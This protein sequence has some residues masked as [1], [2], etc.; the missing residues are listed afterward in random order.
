M[1]VAVAPSGTAHGFVGVVPLLRFA[2]RQDR[3]RLAV[4][5]T[6]VTVMW[7][8]ASIALQAL[9]PTAADRQVRAALMASPAAVVLT[10]P[11]Y[12]TQSYTHGAMVAGEMGLMVFVAL[13]IMSAQ[14]V[15]RHTRAEEES[16][17]AELLRAGVAGRRAPFASAV[18]LVLL[19]NLVI[20]VLTGVVLTLTG[21]HAPDAFALGLAG[22]ATGVTCGAIA[23]VAAQVTDHA[24]TAS[25][26]ALAVLG[27]AFVL[28]AAGD[29]QKQ[30]GSALSWLSPLGWAQQIRAFVDL[31]LWPLALSLVLTCALLAAAWLLAAARDLGA[32]VL[33]ARP[34]RARA[35]PSLRGP[36]TL[37]WRL[38]RGSAAAWAVGV[39]A[40]ALASGTF[41]DAVVQMAQEM[42]QLDALLGGAAGAAEAFVALMAKFF[43][44]V[45]TG[46]CLAAA[47]GARHEESAGQLETILGS[48]VSRQRWLLSR[49]AVVVLMGAG[50]LVLA[51]VGL[52]AGAASVEGPTPRLGDLLVAVGAHLPALL[53][54]VGL[55]TLLTG[56]APRRVQLV[57]GWYAFTFVAS[58]YGGLLGL[59]RWAVDLSPFEHVPALAVGRA[60]WGGAG[61]LAAGSALLVGAGVAALRR[62]DI[63]GM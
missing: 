6:S 19:L 36:F 62:R 14:T 24:R 37:A 48:A 7:A 9:Y 49:W 39:A 47:A 1:T 18:V 55:A 54:F 52:W 12:G 20:A 21:L 25:G 15:V 13:A 51:G 44:I 57:W 4:W 29:V 27:L 26:V 11:G 61:V 5:I 50:L 46:S 31:R 30:H 43:A 28:R 45:V 3:V 22:A 38:Q 53:A 32:G 33:S 23:A 8:Y 17:R 63:P 60:G 2:V 10:G 56:W 58:V 42:P 40:F 34:G 41:L 59:P 35:A 16:G